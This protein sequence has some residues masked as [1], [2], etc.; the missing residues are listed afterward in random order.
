MYISSVDIDLPGN[1][2]AISSSFNALFSFFA[3]LFNLANNCCSLTDIAWFLPKLWI[4]FSI[5]WVFLFQLCWLTSSNSIE[6]CLSVKAKSWLQKVS[7]EIPSRFHNSLKVLKV[8]ISSL[9]PHLNILE[10]SELW[11]TV[12]FG[13]IWSSFWSRITSELFSFGHRV[14]SFNWNPIFSKL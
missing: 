7:I 13:I 14:F 5:V 10:L 12:M 6:W 2:W 3:F 9:R 4:L 8:F 11:F 1:K